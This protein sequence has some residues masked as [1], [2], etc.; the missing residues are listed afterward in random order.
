MIKSKRGNNGLRLIAKEIGKI[1]AS[2]LSRIEQ[3]SLPDLNSFMQICYWLEVSPD[4]FQVRSNLSSSN[5]E[6]IVA[7]LR[8]EKILSKETT[9]ALIEMISLAYDSKK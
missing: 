7:H 2:T 8:A 4:E 6:Q 9:T 3:G 1:S 5:K